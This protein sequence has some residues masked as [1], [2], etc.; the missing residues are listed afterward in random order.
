MRLLFGLRLPRP[1]V[2]AVASRLV[3]GP[4]AARLLGVRVG[5]GCRIYSCRVASEYDLVSIGDDTTVSIDVL[6]VTHDG[7]GWLHRDERGRRYRYAPVVIGERCFVG[8]R[9]T[10][11]PGVHVG[12]DSIVAAGAVVTRSVPEGS[13]VAGVPAKVV[14]TTAALRQKMASWPAEA[15]RRGRT[16]EEQRRSITEPEPVPVAQDPPG[17]ATTSDGGERPRADPRGDSPQV[18]C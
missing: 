15:D 12:A 1:L 4:A 2:F 3:G 17:P 6:F 18:R 7:T 10:I 16:P 8:A 13:V 5:S 14:G 9:A 11:M